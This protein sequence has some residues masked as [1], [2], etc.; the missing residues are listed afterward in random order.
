MSKKVNSGTIII[1]T[2][3][4]TISMA[5]VAIGLG[6]VKIPIPDILQTIFGTSGKA[7]YNTIIFEIR[8]PRVLLAMIIGAN[9]AV[10]GAILQAV[11]GNPLADPGLTGVTSG[12]AAFVL[13]IMLVAPQYSN[14]IPISAFVGGILAATVVFIL[15]WNRNGISPI[16]IILAGV[17]VNALAGGVMGYLSVMFS[18]RLPATVQWMNGSLA[19]KGNNALSLIVPYAIIGWVISIFAI[20]KLNIIRM[21]EQVA[22]NLGE[23]V[24]RN[25]ILLSL[26]A[27]FLA[28][29]SVA[30]IGI[31]GFIG[32]IVPHMARLIVGSNYKYLLPMSMVLGALVLL[33]ADTGGRTLFAPME[34][35]AGIL[36]AVVG[37]PYFLYLMKRRK[38]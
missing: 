10:S 17:A 33:V 28:A 12:A 29:I 31:V 3:L 9:M 5:V 13:I 18:D 6:S 14:F 34:I 27:V 4:L 8:L 22:T 16:T 37:G 30:T 23:N 2:L 35:P 38:F 32:L 7:E 19:A 1:F 25:R 36:M 24:N 26:L 11:V 15:A 21:G 20:R